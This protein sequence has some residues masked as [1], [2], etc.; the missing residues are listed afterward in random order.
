MDRVDCTGIA[1]VVKL[2]GFGPRVGH[3]WACKTTCQ[4]GTAAGSSARKM[5]TG[6]AGAKLGGDMTVAGEFTK[7]VDDVIGCWGL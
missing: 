3:C 6:E 2:L 1:N 7:L 4:T 5:A